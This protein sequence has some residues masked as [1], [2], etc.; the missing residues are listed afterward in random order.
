VTVSSRHHIPLVVWILAGLLAH[1]AWG[2]TVRVENPSGNTAVHTQMGVEKVEVR[3][4]PRGRASR[5]DD[6]KRTENPDTLLIQCQPADGAVIDLDITLPHSSALETVTGNGTISIDGLIR[7]AV[8]VTEAGDIKL[9]LPWALMRIGVISEITP[10][11]VVP[12]QIAGLEFAVQ[13][14]GGFWTL[15]DNPTYRYSPALPAM[16]QIPRVRRV[17]P[18]GLP[19][20]IADERTVAYGAVQVRAK[21]L[22]RLELVDA[23]LPLDSWVKP[24]K[25]AAA[26]LAALTDKTPRQKPA[27]QPSRE[28]AV[29]QGGTPVFVSQVRMVNLS[30]SVTDREGRPAQGLQAEDFEVLEDGAPQKASVAKPGETPFSLVLLLD[31][32]ASTKK[33]RPSMLEAAKR[34]IQI[35]GPQDRVAIYIMAQDLLDVVSP[36]TADRER[37]SRLIET[38]PPLGGSTPLYNVIALSLVQESL[39]LSDERSALVVITDGGNNMAP[40]P[41]ALVGSGIVFDALKDALAKSPILLYPI[42]LRGSNTFSNA[43]LTSMQKLAQTSGGLAFPAESIRD[44]EPVYPLVAEELRSVYTVSYYPGNQDFDGRWRR[45]EVRIKRPGFKIRT[46][47]GY[48][49]R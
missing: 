41:D 5:P 37:L 47:D 20:L 10:K 6:V 35:A 38:M 13:P 11:Q 23:P 33:D 29:M 19:E 27:P 14:I 17:G 8:L 30:V 26:A 25:L 44:L 34:F 40:W 42:V 15:R 22:G 7:R 24:P 49:A 4:S 28:D 43:N 9:T 18:E 32:S 1:A 21:S 31:L 16:R 36:L 46:R 3:A 12:A 48:Y 39:H 45:I 2:A